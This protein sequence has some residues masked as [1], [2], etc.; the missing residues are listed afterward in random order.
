MSAS[1]IS[2]TLAN[3][4]PLASATFSEQI[5]RAVARQEAQPHIEI[6]TEVETA[7]CR[8]RSRL[9]LFIEESKNLSDVRETVWPL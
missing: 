9:E 8:V 4:L 6:V 1:L 5:K 3:S 2:A 7:K